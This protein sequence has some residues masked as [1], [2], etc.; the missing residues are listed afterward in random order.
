MICYRFNATR[1][2]LASLMILTRTWMSYNSLPG[3]VVR[4]YRSASIP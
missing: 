2:W 4:Q 3:A 1:P